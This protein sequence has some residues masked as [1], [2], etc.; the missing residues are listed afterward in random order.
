MNSLTLV[1]LYSTACY[2]R[3]ELSACEPIGASKEAILPAKP[4]HRPLTIIHTSDVHLET[5]TFGSGERGVQLRD[6]V[7][8]AFGR[9]IDIANDRNVDMLLVVGDLF[10]SARVS[11]EGLAFA[12]GT[13]ARAKMPVVMIP[14]NHDAHDDRSIVADYAGG[15]RALALRLRGARPRTRAERRVAGRDARVLLRHS[16]AALFERELG[17]GAVGQLRTRPAPLNRTPDGRVANHLPEAASSLRFS[18][19]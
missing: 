6:K 15:H 12:L 4:P 16:G 9:V 19:V 17:V 8:D 14:G 3:P 2:H 1:N 13:I 10:D 18:S 7:R 5:D 11:E